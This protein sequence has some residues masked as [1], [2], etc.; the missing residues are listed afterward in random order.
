VLPLNRLV[1]LDEILNAGYDVEDDDC[2]LHSL[3]DQGGENSKIAEFMKNVARS[4][5]KSIT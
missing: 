4:D 5:V 2:T 1:D 3:V